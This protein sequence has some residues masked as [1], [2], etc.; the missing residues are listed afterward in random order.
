MVDK[1]ALGKCLVIGARPGDRPGLLE[2]EIVRNGPLCSPEPARVVIEGQVVLSQSVPLVAKAAN[3]GAFQCVD[4]A[5]LGVSKQVQVG[6]RRLDIVV[7]HKLLDG[8]Y[9]DPQL[10]SR[11]AKVVTEHMGVYMSKAHKIGCALISG[12]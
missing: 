4:C 8:S 5:A 12:W 11:V 1:T 9:I 10:S 6:L 2:C 7:T 3:A